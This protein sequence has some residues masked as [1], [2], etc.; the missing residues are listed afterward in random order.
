MRTVLVSAAVAVSS[1]A[2]GV[3]HLN[4]LAYLEIWLAF[5]EGGASGASGLVS[6]IRAHPGHRSLQASA[7]GYLKQLALYSQE[8]LAA[9]A[10]VD[11]VE[12]AVAELQAAHPDDAAVQSCTCMLFALLLRATEAEKSGAAILRAGG[13]NATV[14]AMRANRKDPAVQ[15]AACAALS[16][17][18]HAGKKARRAVVKAS[19]IE[20]I[21]DALRDL[22]DVAEVQT[23][24]CSALAI[25]SRDSPVQREAVGRL[26]G[27]GGWWN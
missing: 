3:F 15:A 12:V 10:G 2:F 27:E 18:G 8:G 11:A 1:L 16:A 25:F 24:G 13:V 7:C 26:G 22:P 21:V 14:E 17:L 23:L 9:L 4:G 6:I 20:S 19:G 5:S